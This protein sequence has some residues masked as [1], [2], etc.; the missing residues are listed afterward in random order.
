MIRAAALCSF[1]ALPIAGLACDGAR[2]GGGETAAVHAQ[3]DP[4]SC[5]KKAALVG[6]S[7]SYSTGM[8]AQ[9]VIAEGTPWSFA[10]TLSAT[11]DALASRV[12]APFSVGPDAVRVIANEVLESIADAGLTDARINL[13]GRLLDVD[14]V[15]YFVLTGYQQLNS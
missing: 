14:G 15:Q 10:G 13:E 3:G 5:A 8:M 11:E 2:T 12:A 7:C 4:A 9:R 6:G 1:L